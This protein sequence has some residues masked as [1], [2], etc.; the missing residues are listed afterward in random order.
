MLLQRRITGAPLHGVAMGGG[1]TD[2]PVITGSVHIHWTAATA[3]TCPKFRRYLRMLAVVAAPVVGFT[4]ANPP[5]APLDLWAEW[6]RL[7]EAI[8]G[9]WDEVQ[10]RG[11][12][13]AVVRLNPPTRAALADALAAGDPGSGYQVVHFSGHSAPDGLALEDDLGRTDFVTTDE[14]VALFRDR[15]VQLVVLNACETEAIA[16]RLHQEAGVPAVIATTDS[17]RDDEARLL[18]ARLYAWLAR[19]RSVAEAFAEAIS[20]LRHDYER[21]ELPIPPEQAADPLAYIA[22]RLSMPVLFGDARLT[23]PPAEERATEPFITL[24]EPPS[25]GMEL[26]LIEGFVGRGPELVWIA[27]WL[28]DRPTP[29]IAISGLGG[30]GKSALAAMAVLRGSWH[31]RAVVALS[32]RGNPQ[33]SPDALVPPLDSVLGMGGQL[34]SAPT[35]AERLTRAIEALNRTPTLLLLDNLEDLSETATRAWADFLSRLDPR[36]GSMAICTLRPAVKHPLTDLAGPAHLPLGRLNEPDALRLLTD[37]LTDWDLWDKVPLVKKLPLVQRERLKA[38]A[39]RAYLDWLPL[40]YLAALDELAEK[41]GR[42]PY[43]LRLALGDLRYPHVDW[44]KALRNVSDLQGRD[45]EAQAEAMVGRMVAD[46]AQADPEA[47]ALLQ[48]FLVFQGGATY[49]ALW[50]VA[51][52]NTG[53]MAFN[54]HLRTALD[55]SLLEARGSAGLVRYDLHP[56]TRAYL[57]RQRPLDSATLTKL[58]RRHAMY[59]TEWAQHHQNEAERIVGELSNLEAAYAFFATAGGAFDKD[60][61]KF[62]SI[63]QPALDKSGY[64]GTLIPMLKEAQQTCAK[65]GDN[66]KRVKLV[67]TLAQM[68]TNQ[69]AYESALHWAQKAINLAQQIGELGTLAEAHLRMGWTYLYLAEFTKALKH[70]KQSEII[71]KQAGRLD[72]LGSALHFTA[73]VHAERGDFERALN[74]FRAELQLPQE[75]KSLGAWAFTWLRGGEILLG[76]GKVK[77]AKRLVLKSLRRFQ[78]LELE[79]GV[80]YCLRELAQINLKEGKA[81][82][83]LYLLDQALHKIGFKR[84]EMN[85]RQDMVEVYIQLGYLDEANNLVDKVIRY[86]KASKERKRLAEA[87]YLKGRV[88]EALGNFEEA[89]QFYEKSLDLIESIE[90][91]PQVSEKPRFAINRLKSILS[92]RC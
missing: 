40:E 60:L 7:E 24:A 84:G 63:V 29:V 82:Q 6:R 20:A 85:V 65:L 66:L 59:F 47:V 14:L 49:E 16:R 69:S 48:T 56:L 55:A 72:L 68:Y 50:A 26:G 74:Y 18:T 30:I 38:L 88:L 1:V 92:D 71:A 39:H 58:R 45:W 44:A 70:L 28:R 41:A 8:R 89:L 10:E 91:L 78:A 46:L 13:W 83:A 3:P 81:E 25:R 19:G 75:A 90:C 5:P 22:E 4:E 87:F 54:D 62:V 43:A 37:G 23:L 42:H 36:R 12:P 27:R 33:L 15:L 2:S 76:M 86:R 53:E 9:T 79:G 51:A 17:L 34:A 61:V 21:G 32:A 35:E 31:F 73:R 52:P 11:A 67:A 64:W 77:L 80:A 57:N